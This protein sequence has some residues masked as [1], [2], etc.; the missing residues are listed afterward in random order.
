MTWP[1]LGLPSLIPILVLLLGLGWAATLLRAGQREAAAEAA[2]PPE[3]RFVIVDGLRVHALVVGEGPDLV[4]IHGSSGNLRDFTFHFLDL[5]KDRYRVIVFDRPGLGYSDRLPKGS[6][7]IFNRA[8]HLSKAAALLGAKRPIVLGHSLGGAVALAWALEHPAAALVTVSG[9]SHSWDGALPLLFRVNASALGSAVAVPLIT[10]W[11]PAAFARQQVASVFAPQAMPEGYDFAIGVGLTLRRTSLRAN[12]AQ[13]A[14]LKA[15]IAAMAPR[16]PALTLPFEL[17]HGDADAIV[18]FDV[19]AAPM[20]IEAPGAVLTRLPGIG[21][22]PHQVSGP[23]V[24]AAI[25][26]AAARAGL[27]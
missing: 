16:Y 18:H 14:T 5:V 25:D 19:H 7:D 27:R 22:M 20:A 24:A 1:K 3:G 10:A 13:R 15:E 2:F 6:E 12:A 8:R 17:L 4:L 23:E 26:R 21:H 9:P 11:T